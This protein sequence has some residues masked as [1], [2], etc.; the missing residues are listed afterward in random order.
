M[1]NSARILGGHAD[2]TNPAL[3]GASHL[4][5]VKRT[6]MNSLVNLLDIWELE[7]VAKGLSLCVGRSWW[8]TYGLTT[9]AFGSEAEIRGGMP[10]GGILPNAIC[11]TGDTV[12]IEELDSTADRYHVSAAVMYL[13]SAHA[14]DKEDP[15]GPLVKIT[16]GGKDGARLFR[17]D[18]LHY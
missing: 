14:P 16:M 9:P 3:T 6:L 18:D 2:A 12:Y 5:N 1:Y 10:M 4:D 17:R 11:F 7:L 13:G 15:N 8:A